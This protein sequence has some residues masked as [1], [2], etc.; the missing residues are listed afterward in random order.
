V[1]A[2]VELCINQLFDASAKSE[3]KAICEKFDSELGALGKL[4]DLADSGVSSGMAFWKDD[5]RLA[6]WSSPCTK[7]RQELMNPLP[8]HLFAEPP[9]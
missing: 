1:K 7:R 5:E 6:N 8:R 2:S 9:K 3:H 4:N